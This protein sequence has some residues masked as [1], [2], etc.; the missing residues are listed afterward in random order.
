MET[1]NLQALEVHKGVFLLKNVVLADNQEHYCSQFLQPTEVSFSQ[2]S[3]TPFQ[4]NPFFS[5]CQ[6]YSI[7]WKSTP[8]EK[9]QTVSD[10]VT[11]ISQKIHESLYG[12]TGLWSKLAEDGCS[13][14]HQGRPVC[15]CTDKTPRYPRSTQLNCVEALAYRKGSRRDWHRDANWMVGLSFGNTVK[16]GFQRLEDD[17]PVVVEIESGNAVIFNGGLHKHAVLG[18]IEETAPGWWKYPF[19]RVV[20]LMRDFRQS[21]KAYR[22][23]LKRQEAAIEGGKMAAKVAAS[24][25]HIEDVENNDEEGK[26]GED[27]EV[28]WWI[29]EEIDNEQ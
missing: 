18:I 25:L 5:F 6:L 24:L 1:D 26:E 23:K 7:R 11:T 14:D 20:F 13:E 21:N 29:T 9:I 12:K 15:N 16:M 27:E 8:V 10:I 17:E 22:R 3:S 4:S 19:S 28:P 2:F